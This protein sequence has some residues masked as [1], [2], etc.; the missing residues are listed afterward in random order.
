SDVIVR[1][2]E[3]RINLDGDLALSDRFIALALEAIRP[4]E[5]GMG[6]RCGVECNGFLVEPNRLVQL[7]RQLMIHGLFNQLHGAFLF[8]P[9]CLYR[10]R[11]T[12][13]RRTPI[14]FI[15]HSSLFILS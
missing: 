11:R 1:I 9:C 3:L 14:F 10:W 5:I 12:R 8:F 15:L 4:T 6:I 7:S 13:W 2:A